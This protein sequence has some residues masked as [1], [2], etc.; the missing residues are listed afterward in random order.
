MMVGSCVMTVPEYLQLA[1]TCLTRV[2]AWLEDFDPDEVD[3]STTDGMVSIEFPDKARFVLN[4]QSGNHQMWFAAGVRA[5]H[6][7]WSP[8]RDDL[9]RRPRRARHLRAHRRG[10]V[11]EAR[12]AA[13]RSTADRT[14]AAM[15]A[16]RPAPRILELGDGFYDAVEPARFPAAPAALPQ[17]ALGGARRA[18]RARR[19]RVGASL[20][21]VRAAAGEPRAAAGAALP[22]PP[23]PRR[24]T[25]RSATAAA[26][27]FAQ[28]LDDDGRLL[29]LGTK[30]SGQT[31][32][33]RDGDGRL[34]LKGGVR[35]VL[36]TEMLEALG[37]YTSK[38]F[39]LFETGEQLWR[40][41]EPSPTR[42]SVLV[43]LGHSHV[44]FGS[45]QRHSRSA[46]ARASR[47]L[48]DYSVAP[49][50]ARSGGRRGRGH[51]VRVPARRVRAQRAALRVAG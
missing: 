32:W 7:D 50:R 17:P 51:A 44:R 2:A 9:G 3:F 46:T 42:S 48:L 41:D 45:F 22:R 29:D 34:T 47:A 15:A 25:R 33:S 28:L 13:S 10:G 30:G 40:G 36:A 37:V 39:S 31:P 14:N 6:Y 24:T 11:R 16:Y 49:L 19:R 23:V 4:R 21:R 43:R 27:S 8:E 35:E 38:T 20:R 18:R 26:S 5:W 12:P 1:D